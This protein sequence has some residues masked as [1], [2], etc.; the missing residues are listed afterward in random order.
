M[1]FEVLNQMGKKVKC[2]VVGLFKDDK[3]NINYIVYTDGTKDDDG[4][5][6]VYASRF[7]KRNKFYILQD[8]E[9]DYEWDLVD[10]FLAKKDNE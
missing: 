9:E 6:A 2:D 7:N 4:K 10:E 5:L 3:R 8:I 1:N